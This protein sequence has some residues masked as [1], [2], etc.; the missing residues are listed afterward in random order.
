MA[1]NNKGKDLEVPTGTADHYRASTL[2]AGTSAI[3]TTKPA[4]NGG[5]II[6]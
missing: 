5:S 3:E 2:P 4:I 6:E 1:G